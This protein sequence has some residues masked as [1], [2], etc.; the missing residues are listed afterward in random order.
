MSSDDFHPVK[1]TA[2]AIKGRGTANNTQGRF[3]ITAVE[4]DE[5][6]EPVVAPQTEVRYEYAKSIIT[7]NQSPDVPFN[8]SVNPYRG[9]EH[10]CIY[11]FARP[12]HAYLDLSP[13]LD[14][15][16]KL[17]AKVNAPA[18]FEQQLSKASYQCQ[19]IAI[20]INTD[21]YQPIEKD[22]RITR[23]LL[24]I[25]LL[26]KQP[27]SIITKSN[28]ILRDLDIIREL[29]AQRLFHAA[30]SV[31]TLDNDL[32]R[33]LEPRTASGQ[34]RLN[35]VKAMTDAG[36]PVTV[37][38]SP[39]IPFVND[40]ELEQ[41]IHAAADAG[42]QSAHYMLLRLPHEL[43]ELFEGWLRTHVPD[44]ADHV[45]NRIRDMRGGALNDAQ[46]GRRMTGQGIFA[47]LI[48]QRFHVA[49]KKAGLGNER[50]TSLDCSQFRVPPK[51]CDQLGLF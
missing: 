1:R 12:S 16:T 3:A 26:Y 22:L 30:V 14:F 48:R 38:A 41:I 51:T 29:A 24:E 39:M 47:D 27:V 19:P 18:L 42:A 20:G 45:L 4:L 35:V 40:S 34:T 2:P 8:L 43:T 50:L 15:E 10:G 44:R 5:S 37:L 17:S 6:D 36:V 21:A 23:Q 25:A 49:L 11:C 28:L 13:G 9:C 7:R 31:T 46:F 33:R 32:K